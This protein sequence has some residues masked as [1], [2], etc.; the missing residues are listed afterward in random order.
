[1]KLQELREFFKSGTVRRLF[2]ER[3]RQYELAQSYQATFANPHFLEGQIV[4]RD[5]LRESGILEVAYDPSDSR[6]YDGKRAMALYL[7]D[8]LRWSPG[9]LAQLGEQITFAQLAP[10]H[11]SAGP[12]QQEAA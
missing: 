2:P 7:L 11:Q 10:G 12:D 1:M 8:K 6:F 4:L 9:E 3:H 5:F